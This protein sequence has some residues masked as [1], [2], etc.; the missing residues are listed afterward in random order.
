[1]RLL[2]IFLLV[3]VSGGIAVV[4]DWIGRRIGKRRLTLLGLRPRSTAMLITILTGM[5]IA[6]FSMG[7]MLAGSQELRDALLYF[8]R[9][10]RDYEQANR[11]L[12]QEQRKLRRQ[13]REARQK[14]AKTQAELK[15]QEQT[16][17][18]QEELLG[19]TERELTQARNDLTQVRR[20]LQAA[21]Q[22]R[23]QA[24]REAE[25]AQ[26]Q[27]FEAQ[28]QLAQLQTQLTQVNAQIA[29]AEVQL[30]EAEQQITNAARI[31][32]G[33]NRA[34]RELQ[35]QIEEARAEIARLEEQR[36]DLQGEAERLGREVAALR[37]RAM[38]LGMLAE[39]AH[40]RLFTAQRGQLI[41]QVEEELARRLVDGTQPREA[42]Q[43]Q[44]EAL[45]AEADE[46]A[47]AAGAGREPDGRHVILAHDA[48]WANRGVVT[49]FGERVL[50]E[51]VNFVLSQHQRLVVQVVAGQNAVEGQ[52]VQ[53]DFRFRPDRLVFAAGEELARTQVDGT[54]SEAEIFSALL[55]LLGQVRATAQERGLLPSPGGQFGELSHAELFAVL[56]AVQQRGAATEV[57]IVAAEDTRTAD[58]LS[59]RFFVAGRPVSAQEKEETYEVTPERGSVRLRLRH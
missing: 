52:L 47:A 44:L 16:L 1:M 14:L 58:P 55:H 18:Q 49:V 48:E 42:V 39:E 41:F 3:L 29:E 28:T 2:A 4:G 56:H 43:Q 30:A 7:A 36:A 8:D 31:V 57:R 26:Q 51:A 27:L 25:Q 19:Q 37:R 20:Q 40:L 21:Q 22:A 10:K 17:L 13:V 53:V 24:R 46:R 32:T 45:L 34:I 12:Q 5:L 33:Q 23:K 15:Q 11:S 50:N 6:G 59:I 9:I 38:E 35:G 54:H